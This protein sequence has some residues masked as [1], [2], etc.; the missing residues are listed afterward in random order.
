MIS[1][2]LRAS[3]WLPEDSDGCATPRFEMTSPVQSYLEDLHTSLAQD[4]S[5]VVAD[6]IPELALADPS[7]FGIALATVDAAI[8]E[9]GDT[10]VPF[11]IQS[12]SKP[13]TF[14]MALESHGEIV[15]ERVGVS[16]PVRRSTRSILIR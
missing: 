7:S 13:L 8:Y 4:D 14:A 16:R 9:V 12:I 15:R 1:A 10:R 11:T 6:Y 3:F 2:L 5:G